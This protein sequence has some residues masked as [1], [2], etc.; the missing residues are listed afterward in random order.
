MTCRKSQALA[1]RMHGPTGCI[2][3]SSGQD[4]D[5]L[6][7][8]DACCCV[9]CTMSASLAASCLSRAASSFFS[10][11]SAI[12]RVCSRRRGSDRRTARRPLELRQVSCCTALARDTNACG[13]SELPHKVSAYG[14]A[15][16]TNQAGRG[17]HA[18]TV[19]RA[20]ENILH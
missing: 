1:C 19:N 17:V 2:K 20:Q 5:V 3:L 9:S 12:S 11:D 7:Q 14:A 18:A 8:Q 16:H 13:M 10:A 15:S 4:S 6:R